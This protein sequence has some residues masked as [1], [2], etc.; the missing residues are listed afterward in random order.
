MGIRFDSNVPAL[1]AQRQTQQ[2]GNRQVRGFE[3]LSTGLRIN[4]ARDDAAGLAVAERFRA[5]VRRYTQEVNNLQTG[6]NVTQTADGAL[7]TQQDALQ[8]LGELATQAANGTLTDQQRAAINEE[9]RQLVEQVNTVARDTEFNGTNLLGGS[10]GTTIPVGTGGELN[11]NIQSSTAESL[12]IAGVDLSTQE[13]AAQA[14]EAVNTASQ[15]VSR[16]RAAIGAQENRF[17]RAV[18]QREVA[19]ENSQSAESMIRDAD[20]ARVVMEQTRNGVLRQA[21]IGALVQANLQGE[22]AAR[23]LGG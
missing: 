7:S 2:A 8:R 6:I 19:I 16:N 10:T 21:G 13:G 11:V 12:G 3:S 17:N 22:T 9:A 14:L 18:A 5:D 15:N 1:N 20:I 23:L 4:R